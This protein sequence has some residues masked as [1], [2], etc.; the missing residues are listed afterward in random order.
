MIKS[1]DFDMGVGGWKIPE[2]QSETG[3]AVLVT[4]NGMARAPGPW[5]RCEQLRGADAGFSPGAA[6]QGRVH[7]CARYSPVLVP[8]LAEASGPRPSLGPALLLPGADH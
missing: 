7:A 6:Q 8:G 1:N 3:V 2:P 4:G 5:A